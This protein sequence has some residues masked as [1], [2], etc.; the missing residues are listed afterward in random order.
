MARGGDIFLVPF[1]RFLDEQIEL[2]SVGLTSESQNSTI[3][4]KGASFIVGRWEG[5]KEN[6]SYFPLAQFAFLRGGKNE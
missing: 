4:G 2:C 5:G 1:L 3:S 6:W